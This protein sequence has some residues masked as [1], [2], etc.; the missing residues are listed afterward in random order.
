VPDPIYLPGGRDARGT[1]DVAAPGASDTAAD[2]PT[3]DGCVVAC[4]PHPQHGGH[5]GDRRLRAIAEELNARGVD[6]LRFDYGPWDG[7]R[8]ER[9]DARHAVEW[10]GERYE[11]VALFGYSFGGAVALS[12]AAN[13]ADVVAVAAL[14]PPARVGAVRAEEGPSDVLGG[15]DAVADLS[16]VPA[17]LSVGV[18]YGSRDDVADV[19]PV[20]DCARERGATVEEFAA[21]HALVGVESEVAGAV[22]EFLRPSLQPES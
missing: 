14:A 15:I 20:V 10:A 17:S 13:G 16:A 2:G 4:P 3:A 6:C 1:L 11:R 12:A 5:R 8:G 21:D 18:F 7:G 9:A 22:V 19:A